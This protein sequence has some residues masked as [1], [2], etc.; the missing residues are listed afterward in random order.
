MS[1]P[2]DGRSTFL[3]MTVTPLFTIGHSNHPIARFVELLRQHAIAA[4]ADVRSMPFSRFHPQFSRGPLARSLAEAG[5]DYL[6]FG[7]ELG[8][9]PKD[10]ECFVDGR[11]DYDRIAA[12][13]QFAAGLARVRA[14]AAVRRVALMCAEREP[15][16]CH[17]VT[18]VCRHLREE[19]LAIAHILADGALESHGALERRLVERLGLAPPPLLGEGAWPRAI[20]DAYAR[21][22]QRMT[23]RRAQPGL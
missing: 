7:E 15:L 21:Q 4:L 14:E 22:A 18:L 9:R 6:F 1:S 8:A 2:A 5:I 20:A 3:L 17:R 19:D 12:R 13:P 11:I 16:D 23:Q 10:P